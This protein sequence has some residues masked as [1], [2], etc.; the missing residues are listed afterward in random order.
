M[1]IGCL[2]LAVLHVFYLF[3]ESKCQCIVKTPNISELS[4]SAGLSWVD[5]IH[6][7]GSN[8]LHFANIEEI[9]H[10]HCLFNER[11]YEKECSELYYN[12]NEKGY[13]CKSC[14]VFYKE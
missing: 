13:L 9:R 6:R 2:P 3:L 7:S 8:K 4:S 14:E 11:R 5:E 12:F 10:D 1:C